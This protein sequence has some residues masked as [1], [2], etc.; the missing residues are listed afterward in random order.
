MVLTVKAAAKAI[1]SAD[2]RPLP[3]ADVDVCIEQD[4]LTLVA[5]A[6]I[7]RL[8]ESGELIGIIDNK[9]VGLRAGAG[10]E[11]ALLRRLGIGLRLCIAQSIPNGCLN[12]VTAFRCA[13]NAVDFGAVRRYDLVKDRCDIVIVPIGLLFLAD[14]LDGGYLAV[15]YGHFDLYLAI[16]EARTGAFIGTVVVAYRRLYEVGVFVRIQRGGVYRRICRKCR[17]HAA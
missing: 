8:C 16:L 7:Y 13:G 9:G 3:V 5:F 1:G 15:G 12:A 17:S 2:R 6:V 11:N 14:E 4:I 10:G